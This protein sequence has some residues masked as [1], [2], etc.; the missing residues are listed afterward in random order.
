MFLF[1][2][3]QNT[4]S[5]LS[6]NAQ[7]SAADSL[8]TNPAI[9]ADG[10]VT[11]FESYAHDLLPNPIET[12]GDIYVRYRAQTNLVIGLPYQVYTPLTER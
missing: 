10:H 11:T 6:V 3:Q 2:R 9:S 5:C 1:D 8:S 12:H 4:I 7:G